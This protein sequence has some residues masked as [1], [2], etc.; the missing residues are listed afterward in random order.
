MEN[1]EF[2]STDETESSP[3]M[4]HRV[5]APRNGQKIGTIIQ[6]L[7]GNRMEVRSVDGKTRNCRVPGR[8]R[9]SLWLR[10]N[11]VILLE[12]WP[13]D[14]TKG[15]IVYKYSTSEIAQLRKKGIID[16]LSEGF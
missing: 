2:E 13:T 11:D 5:R 12:P 6:R 10:P 7:G 4:S 8:F 15:D 16:S 9:R 14:D 3:E 1:E